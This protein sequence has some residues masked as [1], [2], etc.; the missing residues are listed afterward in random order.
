MQI[1][2]YGH[3][4]MMVKSNEGT[5]VFDPYEDGSVPGLKLPQLTADLV[6][7]SHQH[8][9]HNAANKVALTNN[10]KNFNITKI[11]TFHDDKQGALRGPN[12]IHVLKTEG[13]RVVHLGDLGCDLT[14]SEINTLKDCEV[15]MIP[16]GGHYTID[17]EQ[18]LAIIDKLEPRIT[19]PMHYRS[20]TFGYDVISTSDEFKAKAKILKTYKT[21]KLEVTNSTPKQTAFLAVS[22]F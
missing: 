18:A 21:N 15:L 12:T 17:T 10:N 19:I 5:V 22:A 20:D 2:W 3:S 16:I 4:C 14:S 9:D 13:M 8:A 7:C 1:I 6:L 11:E